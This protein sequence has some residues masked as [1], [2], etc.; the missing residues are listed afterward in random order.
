ML[1]E[2]VPWGLGN[3]KMV[4]LVSGYRN[5]RVWPKSGKTLANLCH[6]AENTPQT[7]AHFRTYNELIPQAEA[8]R[9]ILMGRRITI[10]KLSSFWIHSLYLLLIFKMRWK[11]DFYGWNNCLFNLFS[12][13]WQ[14]LVLYDQFVWM[15]VV[16]LSCID[17]MRSAALQCWANYPSN[18]RTRGF[19]GGIRGK[20]KI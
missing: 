12:K 2:P 17:A 18:N 11:R 9:C 5:V 3:L 8:A 16:L 6:I 14:T 10:T 4:V 15:Y 13:S 7:C 1:S 19:K 20:Q